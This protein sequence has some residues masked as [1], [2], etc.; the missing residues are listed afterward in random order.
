M[1]MMWGGIEGKMGGRKRG[2]AFAAG[3]YE[4]RISLF[5]PRKLNFKWL[6]P[7]SLSHRFTDPPLPNMAVFFSIFPQ[8]RISS[9]LSLCRC[10]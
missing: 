6:S 1:M 7:G 2:V 9:D 4:A 10:P 5:T 8:L 3:N